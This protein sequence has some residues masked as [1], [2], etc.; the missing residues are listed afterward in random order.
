MD[1][2]T[3]FQQLSGFVFNR[4]RYVAESIDVPGC[5]CRGLPRGPTK[6]ETHESVDDHVR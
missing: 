3:S 5:W 4:E 1:A 6:G 2:N